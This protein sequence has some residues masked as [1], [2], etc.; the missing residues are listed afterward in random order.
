MSES[1]APVTDVLVPTSLRTWLGAVTEL[2][3]A[4]KLAEPLEVLLGRVAEQAC[5]LIGFDFGAVMLTDPT[6]ERLLV[7]GSHGLSE[8]YVER[9][10]TDVALRLHTPDPG[11]DAPA[12]RAVREGITVTAA[13]IAGLPDFDRLR[14]LAEHEGYRALLAAPL[15]SGGE[16]IGVLVAYS[17]RARVFTASEVELAELLAEHAAVAVE[18]AAL[19]ES[20]QHAIAELTRANEAL[21]AHQDILDRAGEQ[22]R[23]L[24]ELA[25]DDVGLPRL[26][27]WLA[28]T[29]EASVTVESMDG[30]VLAHAPDTGYVAPPGHEAPRARTGPWSTRER[31]ELVEL[32]PWPADDPGAA[33]WETPIVL[34]GEV[35]GRLWLSGSWSAP[36]PVDRRTVERFALVVAFELLKQRHGVEVEAR[37][38]QDVLTDLLRDVG[39][40]IPRALVERAAAL[41]SDLTAP[42]T[43]VVLD[44]DVPE[45]EHGDGDGDDLRS[46]VAR[47]AEAQVAGHRERAGRILVGLHDGALVLL[48]P[49]ERNGPEQIRRVVRRLEQATRPHPISAVIGGTGTSPAEHAASSRAARTALEL[50][51]GSGGGRVLDLSDLGVHALLLEAG[52]APGLAGFAR[53]LLDPLE[54]HDARHGAELVATLRAWLREDCSTTATARALVVHRNT[55]AYRLR[56]IEDLLGHPLRSPSVLLQLQL[57]AVVRD[58]EETG[59]A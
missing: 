9:L 23:R 56:R 38:S 18:T 50:V 53:R 4:V 22:H 17:A 54:A 33:A 31:Y 37:L 2:A 34:A 44:V 12:A 3:R 43:V 25:L 13:D 47:L 51:R 41:G 1:A 19:R 11:V 16:P 40:E 46:W 49:A 58:V 14:R 7:R 27:S 21:R 29:L 52:V 20:E 57:A 26:V 15:R 10:N 30:T 6:G 55:V 28:S 35:A 59:R 48:L 39:T 8:A 32:R 42:H 45:P 36:A 24:M 5:T